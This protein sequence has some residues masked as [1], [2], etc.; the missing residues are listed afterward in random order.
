MLMEREKLEKQ[1]GFGELDY[2]FESIM[3]LFGCKG[4]E[5]E[6]LYEEAD[7][8]RQTFMGNEIY[9]RG[10]IEFSKKVKGPE[11]PEIVKMPKHG[12]GKDMNPCIDCRIF[13]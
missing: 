6:K 3:T 1:Y 10:I 11:Y 5:L 8:I 9:I 7:R 4:E 13:I 12:Y 2:S